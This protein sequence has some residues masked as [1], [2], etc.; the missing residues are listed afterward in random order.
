M[1]QVLCQE[2]EESERGW[3]TRSDGFSLHLDQQALESFKRTYWASMPKNVPEEYSRPS[4]NPFLVEVDDEKH[5]Q[6]V[7]SIVGIRSYERSLPKRV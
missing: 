3:G 5:K 6:I 1:H 4:G 2:W 7:Q